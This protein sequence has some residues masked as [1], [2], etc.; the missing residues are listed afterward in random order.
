MSIIYPLPDRNTI[1]LE[2]PTF[3]LDVNQVA[4]RHPSE[5]DPDLHGLMCL[6]WNY[7]EPHTVELCV[8]PETALEITKGA[9]VYNLGSIAYHRLLKSELY[10]NRPPEANELWSDI[11]YVLWPTVT[12]EQLTPCQISDVNQLFC[13]TISSGSTAINSVFLTLDGNFLKR[14]DE[15]QDK[16]G[17]SVLSPNEAWNSYKPEYSLPIPTNTQLEKLWERQQ[18][19]YTS[20]S[21]NSYL[22]D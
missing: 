9:S 20:I 17:V 7:F 16:Y 21:V 2:L 3:T 1:N 11:R 14:S 8:T 6:D 4:L 15:L 12:N 18:E 10:K 19:F 13:H 5:L 22:H